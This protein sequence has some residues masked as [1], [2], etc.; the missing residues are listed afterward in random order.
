VPQRQHDPGFFAAVVTEHGVRVKLTDGVTMPPRVTLKERERIGPRRDGRPLVEVDIVTG[1]DG[2]PRCRAVRVASTEGGR[3][4]ASADLRWLSVETLVETAVVVAGE[5]ERGTGLAAWG[6]LDELRE[7]MDRTAAAAR[8][9][10]RGIRRKMTPA[11]LARVAQVHRANPNA[12]TRAVAEA[13]DVAHR[14]AG[15]YVHEAR[16]AGLLPPLE[17]K[18]SES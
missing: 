17:P 6:G 7:H 4:V 13:F 1:D 10:R 8:E 18:A 3:D 11:L 14:T 16:K 5:T 12:P 2:I 15:L 9:S